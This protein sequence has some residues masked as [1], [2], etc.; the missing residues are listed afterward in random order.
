MWWLDGTDYSICQEKCREMQRTAARERLA[1]EARLQY[2]DRPQ[3]GQKI[4]VWLGGQL[5]RLGLKLQMDH[6]ISKS[7][8]W[9]ATRS[10]DS[11]R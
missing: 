9:G 7:G 8:A 10:V 4:K 11:L 6:S 5:V 2:Q 3:A 1:A